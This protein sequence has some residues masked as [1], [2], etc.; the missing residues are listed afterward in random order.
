MRSADPRS[1]AALSPPQPGVPCGEP[2]TRAAP[3]M[4]MALVDGLRGFAA[5]WVTAHHFYFALGPTLP[6][7]WPGLVQNIVSLGN[8]GVDV[9]FVLSGFVIALSIYRSRING[10]YVGIFAIRR[11]LRLDPTYWTVIGLTC[12]TTLV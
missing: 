5:L 4:R 6:S 10:P 8:H 1:D 12:V 2:V 7:F 11:S 3:Q 9:F